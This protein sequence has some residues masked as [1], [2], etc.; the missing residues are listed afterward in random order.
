MEWGHLKVA[1]SRCGANWNYFFKKKDN[2]QILEVGFVQRQMLEAALLLKTR[3]VDFS[4][5]PSFLLIVDTCL[6]QR[7]RRD[8]IHN[9]Q[10]VVVRVTV[11]KG[12]FVF[13][14]GPDDWLEVLTEALSL[15]ALFP[16]QL[17][18]CYQRRCVPKVSSVPI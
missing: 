10:G 12:E 2:C 18:P 5:A 13:C 14:H 11:G 9:K 6:T 7:P 3:G 8:H 17:C 4:K 15:V 16:L 1:H